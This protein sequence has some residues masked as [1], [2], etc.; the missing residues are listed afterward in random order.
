M[1]VKVRDDPLEGEATCPRDSMPNRPLRTFWAPVIRGRDEELATI[2]STIDEVR[3]G[4]GAIVV[5]EARAGMGKSRL[6]AEAERIAR[7][8]AFRIAAGAADPGATVVEMSA[9]L[10]ALADSPDHV[11]DLSHLD[12]PGSA[13]ERRYWLL[14]DLAHLLEE[15]AAHDPLL[16]TL[17]DAQWADAGT[18]AGLRFLPA[19]LPDA[20]IMWLIASRPDEGSAEVRETLRHLA[21]S[22]E[23][24]IL[25]QPL[26]DAAVSDV[27]RDVMQAEP[28]TSVLEIAL[29]SHGSPFVLVELLQGMREEDLVR[30]D[31]GRA[32][33]VEARMP[34]RVRTT[35]QERLARLSDT[36]QAAASVAA[37]LG[38]QFAFADVA[39]MLDRPPSSLL[40]PLRELIGAGL[41]AEQGSTLSFQHDLIREA[42]RATVPASAAQALD[43]QAVDILLA[44]GASP[45]DV[46]LQLA[47]SA[48]PADEVAIE[49]LLK[50]A[51]ALAQTDPAAAVEL[52]K[53]A[54][55]LAPHHHPLRSPLVALTTVCLHA[56]GH[57]EEATAFADT[58]LR[59]IL[60]ANEE[61]EL[62]LSI[63]EMFRISPDVRVAASRRALALPGVDP[64]IR[65]QHLARLVY[66]LQVGGRPEEAR[67]LLAQAQAAVEAN[68]APGAAFA[69]G[70]GMGGLQNVEGDFKGSLESIEAALRLGRSAGDHARERIA[71][72]FLCGALIVLDRVDEALELAAQADE[73]ARRDRQA[74]AMHMLDLWRGRELQQLGRLDEASALLTPHFTPEALLPA[75][76]DAAAVAALGRIAIHT[77][78]GELTQRTTE[79]AHVMLKESSPGVRRHAAWLLALQAFDAGDALAARDWLTALGVQERRTVI[80]RFPMDVTDEVQL[81]RIAISSSD[82]ELAQ[83][84]LASA[85][86]RASLNPIVASVTAVAAHVR[87]LVNE[88]V[89]DLVEAVLLFERTPRRLALAAALEDLGGARIG[90]GPDPEGVD[91]LD[92]ALSI[93]DALGASHDAGR[94]R[95]ALRSQGIR[96]RS[97]PSPRSG[98]GWAAMTDAELAVAQLVAQGLTNRRVAERL[99]VSPHT[100]GS[101]LRQVFAK[102]GIKSRGELIRMASHAD[103]DPG[104]TGAERPAT[105][106]PA[107]SVR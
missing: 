12:F 81:A 11:V 4:R 103:A 101:H 62:R 58:V 5:V 43:R 91:A 1:S 47:T 15:A 73:D 41:V 28:G 100:V 61:A 85:E 66:N 51:Q 44:R 75:V 22:A 9:L 64:A 50:A 38:R 87:G 24:R 79:L 76:G 69:L 52:G 89:E 59:E 68:A 32:E 34:D 2:G 104:P 55:E 90:E 53:R 25:L 57:A 98:A 96:R 33:L 26:S 48:Q 54:L 60:P 88:N 83:H 105:E 93:Y 65:T 67:A 23:R 95:A 21:Q 82:R 102:L 94:V 3:S 56:T 46:A 13:P 70:L 42:V 8:M 78:D 63:A 20:P 80:P 106:Q 39:E 86:R 49:T 84:A 37:S 92:R 36:A 107:T 40:T 10:G 16:I 99:F 71:T 7:R 27:A 6:L 29:G 17:D 31:H 30:V 35:M 72:Q 19:R 74:W 18:A 77:G 14:H 45:V 97:T